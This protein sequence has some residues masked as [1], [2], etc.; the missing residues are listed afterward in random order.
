MLFFVK[1][2]FFQGWVLYEN[3]FCNLGRNLKEIIKSESDFTKNE[4]RIKKEESPFAKYIPSMEEIRELTG[5]DFISLSYFVKM[6]VDVMDWELDE[7]IIW[8][9]QWPLN[10]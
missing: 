7:D 10:V 2:Y 6:Y 9:Y 4:E 3:L 5:R 8:P 1:F